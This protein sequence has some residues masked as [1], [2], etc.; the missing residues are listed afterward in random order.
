[1]NGARRT[2]KLIGAREAA[3]LVGLD[4]ATIRRLARSGE[5]PST[6][7]GNQWRFDARALERWA[8]RADRRR[9]APPKPS[10]DAE[11]RAL[12][13]AAFPVVGIG[14]SAGG[15]EALELFF[16][17]VPLD[18]G[19]A[20]VVVQHLDPTHQGMLVEL[21]QRA[22]PIAVVQ[23][24]E[25][26]PVFPNH[27][28]VIPP[29]RDLSIRSGVLHL[30]APTTARG[31]RLPID[32]FFRELAA[33]RRHRAI[34]VVLSGMGSDGTLG[35]AAIKAH[36]GAVFVQSPATAKFDGMPSSALATGLVDVVAPVEQLAARVLAYR[37]PT[38][39]VDSENTATPAVDDAVDRI[40]SILR[41]HTGQEFSQYKRTTIL[42]RIERRMAVHQ[43]EALDGYIRYLE[44]N[45]PEAGLLFKEL[46]IGVTRFF[47][48]PQAWDVVRNDAIPKMLAE[49]PTGGVL[50]AWV[51]GCSTGEEA[52]SLSIVLDEAIGELRSGPRPTVQIFATDL[53]QDAIDRARAGR[54]PASIASDVSA[55]RLARYFVEDEHGYRVRQVI[56]ERVIFAV[57]NVG[58][59]PPF[60]RLDVL[61][62]RNLLIYLDPELQRRVLALFHYSLVRGG[63]LFIGSA[64][65]LGEAAASFSS[66]DAGARVF[67]RIDRPGPAATLAFPS[68]FT[69]R[70][71][72]DGAPARRPVTVNLQSAV[73]RLILHRHSPPLV[74][75][76]RQGDILYVS[77]RT[78]KYLEPSAGKANWNIH[79]MARDGLRHALDAAF[80]RALREQRSITASALRPEA[81]GVT[82]D[83]TIEVLTEPAVLE[84][85]VLITFVDAIA[86]AEPSKP[87]GRGS[88]RVAELELE[89]RRVQEILRAARHDMQTTA[90]ER[91]SANEE[92]QSSNEELQSTNEELTT[93]KEEMQSLNE[94]LQTLN[95]EL[96]SKLDE[97]SR[98]NDDMRNLLDSTDIAT[99]FLDEELKVRRYTPQMM[100]IIN[101]I[102]GDLHRPITDLASDLVYPTLVA[103]AREVLRTLVYRETPATTMDGRWY[104]VRIMPY[105][106]LGNR[107]DGLVIT[108]V[109]ISTA[110]AL[111]AELHDERQ[112]RRG[113]P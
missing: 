80:S 11:P 107:I 28:Y 91:M 18:S 111:E 56:R 78:G 19:M 23:A 59:D 9:A 81:D 65:T 10:A 50:R 35:V 76:N 104:S 25:R 86:I 75:T 85:T 88:S 110:K 30:H 27:I 71:S 63:V 77:G 108:F 100:K 39:P 6:Q 22:V 21:L 106:T 72:L 4:V 84:D 112:R 62:C 70:P 49:R 69:M 98:T 45:P 1:M 90:E 94:E 2:K 17:G 16:H 101:L 15:L 8:K 13:A 36:G 41:T 109:D 74:V 67:R 68:S 97:L 38:S 34:A 44:E 93:S 20:F 47:R 58:M 37:G 96:Q 48:D 5:L 12:E 64:E 52:Y 95:Q 57:Q 51:A 89:L 55:E 83:V 33:E 113:P 42:R 60:T 82:V 7:V 87:R 53:D 99:L 92:L 3:T 31:H 26:M 61:T 29:D 79:A 24:A 40:C 66:V 103:D 43:I 46:L 32:F 14:T 73:E 54:Y 105:R 102:P